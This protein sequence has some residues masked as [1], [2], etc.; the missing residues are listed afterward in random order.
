MFKFLF[1]VY[2]YNQLRFL[3]LNIYKMCLCKN[4]VFFNCLYHVNENFDKYVKC[5]YL[6]KNYNLNFLNIIKYY[7]LNEKC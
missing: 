7:C 1:T 5:I 4:C 3:D 6:K 2:Y